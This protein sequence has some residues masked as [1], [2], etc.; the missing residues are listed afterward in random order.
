MN[1]RITATVAGFCLVLATLAMAQVDHADFDEL[2]IEF[3]DGPS[4]TRACLECHD[5]EAAEVHATLHWTWRQPDDE[6]GL[7]GKAAHTINNFCINV[8]S[9]WPRC[10]SCHVGYGWKDASFDF[11]SEEAVDCLICHEQTGTYVK[12]PKGAGH[13][14]KEPTMFG[15]KMYSPPDWNAVAQSVGQPSLQNCGGCHFNGGG[16]DAVKHGDLDS[17]MLTAS[18]DLD[19]H[20]SADGANLDCVDCHTTV[21][22]QVAGRQY[23]L[24]AS[25]KDAMFAEAGVES[26]LACEACH[27][28]E[29]HSKSMLNKHTAKVSCQ[30]CHIPVYARGQSTK[31]W[32]DWSQAGTRD[33][34]G[35]PVVIKGVDG[36]SIYDGKKGAFSWERDLTPEFYWYDGS[37]NY[38]AIEDKIDPTTEVWLQTPNGRRDD[39]ASKLYPFKIHRGKTPYDTQLNNMVVPK[40]LGA[41]GT[42]A[43]WGDFNWDEAIRLGMASVDAPYSGEFGFVETAYAYPVT[44]QVAPKEMTTDCV[45]CH[46][47]KGS[48]ELKPGLG[49][50]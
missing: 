36:K 19:V 23:T 30:A 24:P 49:E 1:V 26:Q 33:A 32:W 29:P 40:L 13:P 44:H 28:A 20:M 12:F 5:G 25:S 37:M 7:L 22:H 8:N 10:T 6:T 42:G 27:T 41:A 3:T 34:N 15:G 38:V 2:K 50:I 35:K 31:T 16:G 4:V 18:R 48:K 21:D 9:N 11:T 45:A 14:A 43:Y 46:V 47:K 39:P 17:S